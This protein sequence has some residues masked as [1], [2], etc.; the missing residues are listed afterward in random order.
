MGRE[1]Q[2]EISFCG[3]KETTKLIYTTSL[4]YK[5]TGH[6]RKGSRCVPF[7]RVG[8]RVGSKASKFLGKTHGILIFDVVEPVSTAPC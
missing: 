5:M 8:R 1:K 7:E 4:P 2:R 6:V 3:S